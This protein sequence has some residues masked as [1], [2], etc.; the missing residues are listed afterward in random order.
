MSP[1]PPKR[2]LHVLL[3]RCASCLL[4][5]GISLLAA[6]DSK[7]QEAPADNVVLVSID[8]LRSEFYLDRSWPAPFLQ[9]MAAEGAFAETVRGVFPTLTYPSH[10][11]MV[12]GALP[13]RH[14]VFYNTPFETNGPTGLWYW[15]YDSIR[16]ETIWDAARSAGLT[17]ASIHWPVTLGAPIDFNVPEAWPL[18][19]NI[20]RRTFL[21][22]VTNPP[23]LY[24]ELEREAV[25]KLVDYNASGPTERWRYR[26]L[27][28][29]ATKMTAYLLAT[30]RPNLLTLHLLSLD[31][32]EHEGL[33][34]P[35]V[36]EALAAV[37]ALVGYISNTIETLGM[38]DR[39]TL[40]VA[41]DHGF[42][43]I[44]TLI[45]PNVWL[46]ENDLLGPEKNRGDWKAAFHTKGGAAF[47]HL[48]TPGDRNTL[49]RVSEILNGLPET[50]RARFEVLTREDLLSLGADTTAALA[51][52]ARPGTGFSGA[53]QPPDVVA[54][55]G[56]T[57]GFLPDAARSIY[58]GLIAKGPGIRRGAFAAQINL[59]DV[60]PLIGNLLGIE[61]ETPDGRLPVSLIA[62]DPTR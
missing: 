6:P 25:G 42:I 46:V 52:A 45:A 2:F 61:F 1:R 22:Q 49:D 47:L 9:R 34:T 53:N 15:A 21:S 44:D 16:V 20:S 13:I 56:A 38:S 50:T 54:S 7:A 12:T 32:A 59:V 36:R 37:D 43:G 57:H 4:L 27:D 40:I 26:F 28:A 8:G 51:L 35:A 30:R 62:A 17:T 19:P 24:E 5:L 41:G 48:R 3:G 10:T 39:T 31:D 55:S 23:D 60:A 14:G 33:D 29:A 18:D 58:T 11:S